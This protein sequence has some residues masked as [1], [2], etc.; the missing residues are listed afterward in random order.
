[1]SHEALAVTMASTT[2]IRSTQV[3]IENH[4]WVRSNLGLIIWFPCCYYTQLIINSWHKPTI[5]IFVCYFLQG[6]LLYNITQ[7]SFLS[8]YNIWAYTY[9]KSQGDSL[10]SLVWNRLLVRH[11]DFVLETNWKED[12]GEHHTTLSNTWRS[13]YCHI[14]SVSKGRGYFSFVPFANCLFQRWMKKT[15]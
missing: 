1:M 10:L 8:K 3:I 11:F 15:I 12:W 13:K 14:Q 4:I 9:T 5:S 2:L 7:C 6:L